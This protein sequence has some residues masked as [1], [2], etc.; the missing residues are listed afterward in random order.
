MRLE[1]LGFVEAVRYL[2]ERSGVMLDDRPITRAQL[3]YAREEALICEW[4][5]KRKQEMLAK[6]ISGELNSELCDEELCGCLG[7]LMGLTRSARDRFALYRAAITAAERKE[8]QEWKEGENRWLKMW[9][10]LGRLSML[11]T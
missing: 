9:L 5:W 6:L 4:W 8:Y 1:G 2:A 7:R 3:A 10:E 11:R